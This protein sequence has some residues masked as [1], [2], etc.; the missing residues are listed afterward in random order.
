V[1]TASYQ[2][3]FTAKTSNEAD[4]AM[5]RL[6]AAGLHP[7]D[8]GLTT[9]LALRPTET[10]FPIEVPVEETEKARKVLEFQSRRRRN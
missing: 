2:K 3:I 10:K 6:Q 1:R 4:A 9:P 8:L 7:A 5:Q